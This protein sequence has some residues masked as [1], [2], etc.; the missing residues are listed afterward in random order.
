LGCPSGQQESAGLC[1]PNCKNGFTGIGPLCWLSC[2]GAYTHSCAAGLCTL[3]SSHCAKYIKLIVG[4]VVK[5]VSDI[6]RLTITEGSDIRI[7]YIY[8]N[9]FKLELIKLINNI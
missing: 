5:I 7:I 2:T 6:I 3:D 9:L 8:I 1:Y 4:D